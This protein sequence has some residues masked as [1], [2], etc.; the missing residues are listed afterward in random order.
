M[1]A[2]RSALWVVRPRRAVAAVT[3]RGTRWGLRAR[4]RTS[5]SRVRSGRATA[6]AD[7]SAAPPAP[8][9]A[10]CPWAVPRAAPSSRRPHACG[11]RGGEERKPSWPLPP[12][13]C[14]LTPALLLP[15]KNKAKPAGGSLGARL[16]FPSP[17]PGPRGAASRPTGNAQSTRFG[18][19]QGGSLRSSVTFGRPLCP[20]SDPVCLLLGRARRT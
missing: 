17:R 12:S 1:A 9:G 11:G 3:G 4:Q 20:L 18:S 6:L 8:G 14:K 5:L 2:G 10:L 13:Y 16:P 19:R 15:Q 7:P